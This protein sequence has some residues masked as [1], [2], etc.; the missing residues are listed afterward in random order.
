VSALLD[1]ARRLVQP[2]P[3]PLALDGRRIVVTHGD[4]VETDAPAALR[5]AFA[6]YLA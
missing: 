3:R 6:A 5:R 4:V 2:P 1:R